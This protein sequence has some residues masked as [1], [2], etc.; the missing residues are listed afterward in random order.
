MAITG[1]PSP[2]TRLNFSVT[3]PPNGLLFAM[4]ATGKI[5]VERFRVGNRLVLE[6]R[7][8]K[9]FADELTGESA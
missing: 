6:S 5:P 7:A 2:K 3:I 4:L 9:S 8:K 1:L